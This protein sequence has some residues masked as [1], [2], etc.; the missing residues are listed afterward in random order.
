MVFANRK[1]YVKTVSRVLVLVLASGI[2]LRADVTMPQVFSDHAVLQHG[3]PVPVWGTAA[4]G[5]QV[6][7]SYLD[8]KQSI[9]AGTDGKWAVKLTAL[10]A[11][12]AG[13]LVVTGSN[14]LTFKDVVTGQ[15]WVCSGQSNM[16]LPV[17]NASDQKNEI[18]AADHPQ[19]R[20]FTAPRKDIGGTWEV[21]SPQTVAPFSATAY[22]FGR[23]LQET[24]KMP[25]GLINASVGGTPISAW[26]ANGG[27]YRSM[28]A[29][30][31]PYAISG[32]IWYQGE[33]DARPTPQISSSYETKLTNLIA[34]W[35][36]N[37]GYDFPFAWA[38]LPNYQ[39]R[40][41]TPVEELSLWAPMREAMLKARSIPNTGMAITI[42]LGG[43][44]SAPLHP[45]N[46]QDVGKR[47]AQ[48]ALAKVY[49]IP[50]VAESGPLPVKHEIKGREVTVTFAH[51]DGGLVA[52][53]DALKGFAITGEDHNWVWA[54]AR[55][56]GEK[57]ILSSTTV[58]KPV[59]V[60]YAW[61]ENPFVSLYNGAGLPASPFRTDDFPLSDQ[62]IVP[63]AVKAPVAASPSPVPP[64]Q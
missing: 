5:E 7:V 37:W 64:V 35:R 13:D 23:Q 43:G 27:L 45:A 41:Q 52:R 24:L 28:I 20:L 12:Q 30:V 58:E 26:T 6:T 60:R 51:T 9:T 54:D 1:I 42:D 63:A 50:G 16:A 57:V 11:S 14:T 34:G 21:C 53:G 25:V 40:Q 22:Y 2:S 29:P 32:A 39:K 19:I 18:A 47:F 10:K 17:H 48:W 46:K 38:Q 8:Q 55:I 59:A 3:L 33:A 56:E 15:V 44:D 36:K 61:A 49:G 62:P 31:V 4:P